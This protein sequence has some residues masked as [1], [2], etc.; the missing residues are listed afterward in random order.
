M[1]LGT[2]FHYK[3]NQMQVISLYF[4]ASEAKRAENVLI[5]YA[6]YEIQKMELIHLII[7]SVILFSSLI[8]FE[9]L[10]FQSQQ[11]T[12]GNKCMG[13]HVVCAPLH[14]YVTICRVWIPLSH[15]HM[16]HYT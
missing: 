2:L 11:S 7:R 4:P 3:L 14:L 16:F 8:V 15:V 12:M 9:Q 1:I 5:I 10:F 13:C 6:K